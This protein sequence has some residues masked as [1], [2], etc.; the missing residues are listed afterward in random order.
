MGDNLNET[1][2]LSPTP[3]IIAPIIVGDFGE[4]KEN[5]TTAIGATSSHKTTPTLSLKVQKSILSFLNRRKGK[6]N[7]AYID[8]IR[9]TFSR[10]RLISLY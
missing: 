6:N 2:Y 3:S 7:L 1:S 10:S 5:E 9:K 8:K 4:S